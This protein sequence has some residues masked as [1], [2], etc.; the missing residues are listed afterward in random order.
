MEVSVGVAE[1]SA[2]EV[3]QAVGNQTVFSKS[4]GLLTVLMNGTGSTIMKNTTASFLSDAE[5]VRIEDCIKAAEQSTSGEIVVIVAPSSSRYALANVTCA[6]FLAY[7]FAIGLTPLV[8]GLL[9]VGFWNM[10]VFLAI[11]TLVFVGFHELARRTLWMKRPFI[12]RREMES[13]VKDAAFTNFFKHGLHRTRHETGVLL[14]ISLFERKAWILG[15]RG[16][17]GKIGEGTW[18]EIVDRVTKGISE[19]RQAEAICGGIGQIGALLAEHF[20]IQPGDQDE[21]KPGIILDSEQRD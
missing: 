17:H 18:K 9:W 6:L 16:I 13:K 10:W 8:G 4:G 15:D 7:L 3:L 5:T 11:H 14:F 21:L 1:G 19:N 20:P 12:P 2:G